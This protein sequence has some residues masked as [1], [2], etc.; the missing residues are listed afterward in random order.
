MRPIRYWILIESVF[1]CLLYSCRGSG[2]NKIHKESLP[3]SIKNGKV[4]AVRYCQSCH[5]LPDPSLLDKKSWRDGVLPNMGPRLGIFQYFETYPSSRRDKDLDPGF[6]PSKPVLEPDEWQNIIDY[7]TNL[8]PNAL[9]AQ[10]RQYPIEIGLPL[11]KV[12]TPY[13]N[14]KNSISTYVKINP[15]NS[16]YP[17]MI[18]D[19]G[20]R[21][22]YFFNSE[23][24]VKD[25]V[26]CS[27]PVVDI[28]FQQDRM[29]ACEI[30]ILNPNNGRH[31][32]AKFITKANGKLQED[33]VA[34]FESL[35]RPVQIISADLNNDGKTDYLVCEF[36][37][38]TGELSWMEN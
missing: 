4:L 31:G 36:G 29:L 33:S 26:R 6:Y 24:K 30:G 14:Y 37:N 9:P 20:R 18:G 17:L 10:H 16:L 2:E 27:S 7:Y 3:E 34:L 11:F 12:E 21:N 35:K 13:Y 22:L 15:N 28:D 23:L 32:T 5:L 25:S 8:S 38:L 19:A 1:F